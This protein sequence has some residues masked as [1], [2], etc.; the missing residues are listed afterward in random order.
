MILHLVETQHGFIATPHG[1]EPLSW[2]VDA[3]GGELMK[4]AGWRPFEQPRISRWL[5]WKLRAEGH[6]RV[7]ARN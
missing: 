6:L 4:N 5:F 1:E 3:V 7:F 2:F